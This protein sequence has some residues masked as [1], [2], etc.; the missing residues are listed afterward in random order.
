MAQS[1]QIIKKLKYYF[2][3]L[4]FLCIAVLTW[5]IYDLQQPSNKEYGIGVAYLWL[6]VYLPASLFLFCL[7]L[8]IIIKS[9]QHHQLS[10]AQQCYI[11]FFNF[12]QIIILFTYPLFLSPWVRSIIL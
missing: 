12:V 2:G 1:G 8:M 11:I 4:P 9:F 6:T 10:S 5:T 3:P 7:Y